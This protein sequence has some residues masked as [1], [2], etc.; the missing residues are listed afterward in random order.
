MSDERKDKPS[1]Q[2]GPKNEDAPPPEPAET[3][4]PGTSGELKSKAKDSPERGKTQA[5]G[6]TPTPR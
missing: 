6:F 5:D 3:L 4:P 2:S 1:D